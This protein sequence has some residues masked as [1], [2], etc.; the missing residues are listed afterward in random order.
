M[1]VFPILAEYKLIDK[2]NPFKFYKYK[3]LFAQSQ[4]NIP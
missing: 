2:K 4:K 1:F 3:L